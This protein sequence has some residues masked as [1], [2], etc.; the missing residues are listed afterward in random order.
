MGIAEKGGK[1]YRDGGKG[2]AVPGRPGV[3]GP[4]LGGA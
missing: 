3:I 2:N 1:I 4:F